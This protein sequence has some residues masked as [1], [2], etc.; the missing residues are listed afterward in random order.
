MGRGA[1]GSA[2]PIAVMQS[3]DIDMLN[4]SATTEASSQ[5]AFPQRLAAASTHPA[6]ARGTVRTGAPQGAGIV[7]ARR[8]TA[9]NEAAQSEASA[10]LAISETVPLDQS[11]WLESNK[12]Q[13]QESESDHP[14]GQSVIDT[15]V[16]SLFGADNEVLSENGSDSGRLVD[17][18]RRTSGIVQVKHELRDYDIEYQFANSTKTL[19]ELDY[20]T[21]RIL[22]F[23]AETISQIEEE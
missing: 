21:D 20:P 5:A 14:L 6:A 10:S 11:H 7:V 4:T 22:D 9:R 13:I 3:V 2:D 19:G 23:S 12:V 15:K 1:G 8:R 16:N 17:A 18:K